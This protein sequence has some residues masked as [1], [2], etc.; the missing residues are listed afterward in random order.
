MIVDIVNKLSSNRILGVLTATCIGIVGLFLKVIFAPAAT[1]PY[2]KIKELA[3]KNFGSKLLQ[4]KI[5]I[6][7]GSTSGI[8]L[9]T[10]S[11]LYKVLTL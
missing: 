8:G 3:Q 9:E 2:Q 1:F 11:N 10:A 7:T 4:D 6:I 5:A